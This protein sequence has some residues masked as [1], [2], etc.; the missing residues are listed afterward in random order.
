MH[1]GQL[2]R[3]G[4]HGALAGRV[5]QLR[6]GA[7]E[8]RDHASSINNTAAL[9]IVLPER[10]HGVLGAEPDSFDVYGLREVPD[11]FCLQERSEELVSRWKLVNRGGGRGEV[12]RQ[13][14]LPTRCA[15]SICIVGMHDPGVVE[16]DVHTA[17]VVQVCDRGCHRGLGA[18]VAFE[19]L[20]TLGLVGH[21]FVDFGDGGGE[22]RF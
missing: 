15:D 10:K 5:S 19:G 4:Q 20:D 6:R 17:P 12:V 1:D 21:D 7:A 13:D 18:D 9:F 2:P 3:H 14:G 16:H 11:F 22:S 8:E